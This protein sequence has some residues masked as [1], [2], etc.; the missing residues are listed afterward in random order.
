MARIEKTVFISYRRTDVY[1]ALAVYE[2]LK[3]QGYDVFFD[4]R[5][6][7]SGDFEQIITSNIR[8][9]AHFLLILTPTALD[10]C[11]EPG[12]WLRREIETA[13]DEKR[14]IVPLFFKGFR[15]GSPS[16][17]EK[18]T[19]KLRSLNR[20]N[21]LNVHEDYFDEAMHRLRTLFLNIPLDT[22]LHPVSTEVRKVVREEQVA[23]DKALEQIEDVK[24]LVRQVD[25]GPPVRKGESSKPFD[26]YMKELPWRL[27][28]GIA[29]GLFLLA[30]SFWGISKL[31]RISPPA[32]LESTKTPAS[33]L[34]STIPPLPTRTRITTITPPP[35]KTNTPTISLAPPTST[36]GIGSTLISEKDGM[37]LLYVPAGEFIMGSDDV[38]GGNVKRS[39][40]K[41]IHTV[42]LGAFWIDQT[43]VTNKMFSLFISTTGY[44][45]DAEKAGYSTV[46]GSYSSHPV[47]DGVD[48]LHPFGPSSSIS[49]NNDDRLDYPVVHVSWNDAVAYCRWAGRRL[50][51]EA[52]WE[53]AAR[54]TNQN[55]FPWGNKEPDKQLLNLE[56]WGT[57]DGSKVVGSYP[58]GVSPY[59]VYDM[60]GNVKEWVEDWFDVYPGG[61]PQFTDDYGQKYHVVRGGSWVDDAFFVSAT[62]RQYLS[63]TVTISDTGFR[64]AMDATP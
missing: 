64:C 63:P 7:S 50:P 14:N 40:E 28:G 19:G 20:Y 17:S 34:T 62:F 15:F 5:S 9:R 1:T 60:A 21:G 26:M 58:D 39:I 53:K 33:T 44:Q 29:G 41:P 56:G 30:F 36:L 43:E 52:E 55:K 35:A 13:V 42:D 12:D 4:Y 27:L 61:D 45:T 6:I 57:I 11:S 49:S 10:R 23:A 48:W 24:E 3:N 38:W 25:E 22:V 18:L 2:N 59:G 32:A 37:T 16:V 8:A 46:T 31:N 47:T 54:G 51:S